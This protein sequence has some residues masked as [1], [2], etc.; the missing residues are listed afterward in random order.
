[1][2]ADGGGL[3]RTVH[4]SVARADFFDLR[5]RAPLRESRPDRRRRR[6]A[7]RRIRL[8]SAVCRF[9]AGIWIVTA[10]ARVAQR[11]P[12]AQGP[13]RRFGALFS[14]AKPDATLGGSVGAVRVLPGG[15]QRRT[16][17][18]AVGR[19]GADAIGFAIGLLS[20]ER[21]RARHGSRAAL[22]S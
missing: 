7:F 6:R 18:G 2:R 11:Q 3:R 15:L 10:M 1:A 16:K 12:V 19:A 13:R 17:S 21:A 5:V 22:R 4:G 20:A 8:V 9:H 14:G